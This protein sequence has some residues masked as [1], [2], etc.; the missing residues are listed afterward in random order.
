[1]MRGTPRRQFKVCLIGDG[2]VGKTSI[3]RK[4]LG[5]GFKRSYIPT[6]GVDFAQK[7]LMFDNIPTNLVIWD[8][9][10]QDQFQSL[11]KRYY[12]GCRGI[13]LVYSVVDRAGF[14]NAVKWLVEAHD[15]MGQ[16]PALIIAGNKIDL[17]PT[18]PPEETVSYE[19]GKR[20]TENIGTKLNTPTIFIETSALTGENIDDAFSKLVEMMLD[21]AMKRR[22][23]SEET[24]P[25]ASPPGSVSYQT[26]TVD[27]SESQSPQPSQPSEASASMSTA[28]QSDVERHTE[29]TLDP[30][31]ALPADSPYLQ[32]DQIGKDMTKLVSLRNELKIIE[33]D[34]ANI[35]S[36]IETSLLNLR[37]IIH[38]KRIMYEHLKKQ[39]QETRKEW[40]D[41]YEEYLKTEKRKKEEIGKKSKEIEHIRS[42]IDTI[43][44]SIRSRVSELELK[45]MRE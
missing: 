41:A 5:I 29:I 10:G 43:G 38:V 9:A 45:K 7:T 40:A 35:T 34:L 12:D 32:E 3:R 11:R 21:I 8:I 14:D 26:P 4:Y 42:N 30:I 16:L 6:L 18:K 37:N 28:S 17:R 33:Q 39:L 20:F 25:A 36:D 19:E 13:I 22:T 15:Y 24:A 27:T 1:M 2:F 23:P 44:K 31:I